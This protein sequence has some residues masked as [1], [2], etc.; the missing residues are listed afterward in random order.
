MPDA[1]DEAVNAAVNRRT[2]VSYL[3]LADRAEVVSG[4]L[5]IMGGGWDRISPPTLPLGMMIG[6]AVGITVPYREAEDPHHIEVIL[7]RADGERL[8]EFGADITTGR[9]PG[10]RGMDQSVPMAFN[11]PLE[12]TSAGGLVLLANVDGREARRQ[13]IHVVARPG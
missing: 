7:E 12:L 3:L 2:D 6:V 11:F 9:P 1:I 10:T 4:K 5:Y 8:V 13:S